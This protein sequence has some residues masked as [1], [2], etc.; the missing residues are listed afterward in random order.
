[1]EVRLT[2]REAQVM[3]VLW[4]HGPS[5]VSDV[6]EHLADSLAYTTVLTVLRTLEEKGFAHHSLEGRAHRYAPSLDRKTAQRSESR[7]LVQKLF[8]GSIELLLTHL[9]TDE[10]LSKGQIRRIQQLLEKR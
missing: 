6:R 1:M 2:D 7:A 3:A 8:E 5:T 4:I 9:V 10:K